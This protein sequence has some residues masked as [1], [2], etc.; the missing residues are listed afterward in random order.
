MI[1]DTMDRSNP[2]NILITSLSKKVPLVRE[3]RTAMNKIDARGQIHGADSNVNCI[4]RYF[5]DKFWEMAATDRLEPTKVV[6]YCKTNGIR[7][8][9]PTRDGEL[10]F[11]SVYKALFHQNDIA[12]MVPALDGVH[13]CHDKLKFYNVLSNHVDLNPIATFD[14][15][16][17][18]QGDYWVVKERFGA[19]SSNILLNLSSVQALAA[20]KSFSTPIFQPVVQGREYSVD[21]Y[22]AQNAIPKGCIVRTRDVV[23]HGESQVTTTAIRKDIEKV[24][25][26]AAAVIGLQGHVMF[27][28]IVDPSGKIHLIECNC[29][30]GGASPL[31]VA[32]GLDSF[33][34]FFCESS[35]EDLTHLS[36]VRAAQPLRMV[37]YAGDLIVKDR[38]GVFSHEKKAHADIDI[39]P[40]KIGHRS[41][42]PGHPVYIVAELSANH[43]Q[44]YEEALRLIHAAKDAGA[45]AVK[46]QTYTPDTM[47]MDHDSDRFR[48]AK[49]SL[50]EG[51]TLYQLYKEAYMPWE[52]QPKLKKTASELGMDLFSSAYDPTS[53]DFLNAMKVPA[54]KISSFELTDLPL[55][56]CAA[57]TG[58][59]LI[60]STGMATSNEIDQAIATADD[61]GCINMVLL[62]CTSAYPARADSMNLRTL[63]HIART[64]GIPCG[65][66]DHS[67]GIIAP[68]TATTLG[69]CMI[70][71]HFTL[72][73]Q[74]KSADCGSSLEPHEFKA[75]VHAVRTAET[76]LGAVHYGPTAKERESFSF[77]RS[78]YAVDD[79]KA[80]ETITS[81]NIGAIRPAGGLSP[82]HWDAL[83]GRQAIHFIPKGAPITWDV[84]KKK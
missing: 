84:V 41:I 74:N 40:I 1:A 49:G 23:I 83:I 45:D 12:V 69:A 8:I 32:A 73:R 10:I 50:W 6:N 29:R 20:S 28:V 7:V 57:S 65:L 46:L 36:F 17:S 48:H 3:V 44:D 62:I 30:F 76:M 13:T 58:I 21:L 51:K 82:A 31:S 47:T 54:I 80:G 70:E 81:E 63:D 33:Y 55:I 78:L 5:V 16:N 79:I 22:I 60:L 53:V 4:G 2:F 59:P 14:S 52:W 38:D 9:I 68:V 35:G 56:R 61:A 24:C 75:M 11:F 71:K 37:R 72:S 77:R 27:Q 18:E 26:N 39:K 42:G 67:L 15:P 43:R 66:S 19:G 25:L 34:W 64:H